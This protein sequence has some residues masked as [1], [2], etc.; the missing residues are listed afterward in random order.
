MRARC[1]FALAFA[2]VL[3]SA[4]AW[5]HPLYHCRGGYWRQRVAVV[6]R[7]GGEQPVEGRPVSV[8][9]GDAAGQLPLVGQHIEALR[10]IDEAGTDFLYAVV[11]PNGQAL[12]RGTVPAGATL[13]LSAE[14]AGKES[15]TYYV[16]FDNPSAWGVPDFLKGAASGELNGDFEQGTGAFPNGW[17]ENH[18]ADASHR[19]SW[20]AEKPHSGAKCLKTVVDAEAEPSWVGIARQGMGIVPG[21]KYVIT[22]WVRAADAK[23]RVGWFL[24]VGNGLML[25]TPIEDAGEGTYDWRQ[26][27]FS[28]TAPEEAT[29]MMTIGTVLRGTGTAWFDDLSITCDTPEQLAAEVGASERCPMQF[30]PPNEAWELP[31]ADRPRRVAVQVANPLSEA[32]QDLLV[33]CDLGEAL[34]GTAVGDRLRLVRGGK[35]VPF[36]PLGGALLFPAS[37]PGQTVRSYWLYVAKDAATA[38][39]TAGELKLGSEIPSD[40]VF[41][42]A[43]E[44]TDPR[45]YAALLAQTANLVRN[46]SFEDGETVPTDWPGSAEKASLKGVQ[47]GFATPGVFGRR[48]AKIT[49]PHDAQ[50]DWVGW[51]QDVPVVPGHSY[52]FAAWLKTAD[53]RGGTVALYAHQHQPNGELASESPY[54]STGRPPSG[55]ADWALASGITRIPDDGGILQLC[56]VMKAT[57]TVEYDGVL[58]AEVLPATLGRSET[59]S[60]EDGD[61]LAVWPVNPIVKVFRDDLPPTVKSPVL[62]EL[63]RNEQE[64]L[65]LVVRSTRD[66]KGFR[67]ELEIPK[68]ATGKELAVLEQGIVGYVPIDPRS[69]YYQSNAPVWHRMYPTLQGSGDG[70]AG[71]WPDPILPRQAAD[72]AAGECQPLWL[73]FESAADSPAGVYR[74]AVR[75]FAGNQLLRRVPFMVGV[76]DFALPSTHSLAAIYDVRFAGEWWGQPGQTRAQLRDETLRFMAK[77]K[78]CADRVD[79]SPTFRRDGDRIVADF[80]A[81]DQAMAVFFDELHFPRA[82]TPGL[83]Y[84]FGWANPPKVFLGENPYAGEYPYEGEDRLVLRP[85]YKQVYQEC[86]RQYWTHMKEKGWAEKLVLYISDEP[87]FTHPEIRQQMQA[88]CDMIHEVD[89]EIPLYSSTWRHCPE[90]NGYLDVWGVGSYGCFPVEE[91]AARKAAGDRIWFTSDGQ[92]C[93]DT[94]YCA[95]ERLLPHYC[96]SYDVEA[97]EFWG[98]AWLTY[99]PYEYGWHRYKPQSS[100]P[101]SSFYTRYPSGDGF[102]IYPG[103]P[104]GHDGIVSSVRVEAA[105]DGV[106]DYE[107]LT[108]LQ[109]LA[110]QRGDAPA[111]ALLAEAKALVDIPNPG[112]RYSSRILPDPAAVPRLR[113]RLAAN[114]LR[115]EAEA[116]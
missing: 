64:A 33:H 57:G 37:L 47:Y 94:P 101:G 86:L 113:Q 23:G 7:N 36:C 81:Y 52:L 50:P 95:I 100:G 80:T 108:L 48:C 35:P 10:V 75:L 17:A 28:F 45:A 84:Q 49:V 102:L 109:T 38:A 111:K 18:L 30:E 90:W 29:I 51:R 8:A 61:E 58:V 43:T 66:I 59:R 55:T 41:V 112:G 71:W 79:V 11:S 103:G 14:C 91:M 69:S 105:R 44:N 62:V 72:L 46:P 93:T 26:V 73:T 53:V 96:F 99:N 6:V 42:P 31:V 54:L 27:T 13:V 65:Q 89:A 5:H 77:R 82:Y 22:A 2:A 68:H 39:K 67:Y 116:R 107:Y 106:E 9:V 40:Q 21:G 16:Y 3:A 76:W 20:V 85:E 114:I 115:L 24:H 74:G 70:W 12:T 83:F 56:L 15:K 87:H 110:D 63:A 88:I 78:L 1:L 32:R 92:M 60:G 25:Y 97:Y 34:R 19:N 98:V 4:D 104:I